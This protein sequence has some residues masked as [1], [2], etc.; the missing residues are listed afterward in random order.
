MGTVQKLGNS[1]DYIT[2]NGG[3]MVRMIGAYM[4]MVMRFRVP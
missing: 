2:V 3:F 4:N 1:Y